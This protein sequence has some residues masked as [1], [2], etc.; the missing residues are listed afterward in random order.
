MGIHDR[1]YIREQRHGGGGMGMRS[2][3]GRMGMWSA[4]T[5]LII[6]C[7]AVFVVDGMTPQHQYRAQPV[8]FV[9]GIQVRGV[10]E[11]MQIPPEAVPDLS[12]SP[13][14]MGERGVPYF[15]LLDR[16]GG[17]QIGWIEVYPMN[18]LL[19]QYL[20]FSTYRGFFQIEFWRLIGF[21]FLHANLMHILFNMIGLYF[22]GPLVERHLGSK[23]YLAFY[24]LCGIC[25]AL[26]YTLLN[27]GGFALTL[28]GFDEIG[29]PGLL[30]NSP[31]TPLVGAS[32]GVFGVLMAGAFLAPR[33]MVLL[34][35]II[36][37]PLWVLAYG[38]VIFAL[39]VLITGGHNAGG[40]AGHLG[41]ALAGFYFIRRPHHLHGFF[42]FLGWIDPTSHHYRKG[43]GARAPTRSAKVDN[44][45]VDRILDKI[46][47]QGIHSLTENEKRILREA[48]RK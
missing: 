19:S 3:A 35:F 2:A 4:N 41:G 5:W 7:A 40:E 10:P 9:P 14:I 17:T 44:R 12:A 27:L 33:A 32:A 47:Q 25:G 45:E 8:Q 11:G 31:A 6:I 28:F 29:I 22:F 20:H 36:P 23:R 46:N 37:M 30:F 1:D 16:P 48:S 18:G 42:D 21:Q 26:L 34:F 39:F 43:S 38:L 24:L 15:P 13:R